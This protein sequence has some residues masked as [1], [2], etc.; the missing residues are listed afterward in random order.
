[1]RLPCGCRNPLCWQGVARDLRFW[2]AAFGLPRAFGAHPMLLPGE[3]T[4]LAQPFPAAPLGSRG[5]AGI[6][7]RL[8]QCRAVTLGGGGQALA[9]VT[10]AGGARVARLDVQPPELFSVPEIEDPVPATAAPGPRVKALA[11]GRAER[12]A[13]AAAATH[14]TPAGRFGRPGLLAGAWFVHSDFDMGYF[15]PVALDPGQ[16]W[17]DANRSMYLVYSKSP[18]EASS[19]W[20]R[21]V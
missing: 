19:R 20:Q 14:L 10:L 11:R 13:Q 18:P 9:P 21:L 12:A 7:L 2:R 17:A 16:A 8:G 4:A 6:L 5:D 3:R 15:R 1:V